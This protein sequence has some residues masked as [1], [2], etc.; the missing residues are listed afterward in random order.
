VNFIWTRTATILG[1]AIVA[2]LIVW[3]LFGAIWAMATLAL[4]LFAALIF[5]LRNLHGLLV[6]LRDPLKNPVPQGKGVWEHVFSGLYRLVRSFAQQ[7]N[8]VT[9][10]L[11][12][13]RSAAQ[14]MP[15]GV[16]VLDDE[17]RIS[18]CNVT[19]E[20]MFDLDART[21]AGQPILNL[22]RHPA[23]ASY[24]KGGV[25]EEPLT[26]RI[27][28]GEALAL[29][30]RIVSYGQDEKLLL[31]RDTTQAEK[32]ETMRQDFVANVS[33]ELRTPL[34]VV[35]GFLETLAE[36]N[37][38]SDEPR[39]RQALEMMRSQTDR[40]LRLVEDLLMLSTLETNPLPARETV[41]DVEKLLG[42]IVEDARVLSAGRHQVQLHVGEPA[43]LVGDEHEIRSA[44]ANLVSN[45]VRYTPQGGRITLGW[46][47][48][49]EEGV[50][51]VEDTGIGIERRHIP[52]L[53]ERF[54]R[55]DT[56]R[57]R[58]TGGTGLGLA[59][60]KHVLTR[61][62]ARLEIESELGR[63][64]RFEALFP[65]RRVHVTAPSQAH[66]ALEKLTRS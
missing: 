3:P 6:W 24:L 54:Y 44:F 14:A 11:A 17:D 48:R 50:F 10:Q 16:L 55:A 9:V 41:I 22:I 63:G 5:H 62:Q 12:R 42:G 64:S 25:Y 38:R 34:T 35:S 52:R 23:F 53:T 29:S 21:D 56:S 26:L 45:A 13:F 37:I 33:H 65:A 46:G 15:I 20:R 4:G 28:R 18:W 61:H 60:V 36:G 1:S 2:G 66:P 47:Q 40:M 19:A 30:V 51:S 58:D 39:G 57:S 49:G 8:R 7:R 59:I 43:R 27:V 31:T 32:I